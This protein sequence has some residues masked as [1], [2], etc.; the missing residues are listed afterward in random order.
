MTLNE[1]NKLFSMRHALW[2]LTILLKGETHITG[3]KKNM[4]KKYGGYPTYSNI[5]K[6]CVMMEK[7]GLIEKRKV[8]RKHIVSLTLTGKD[9]AENI[10]RA[11]TIL[12]NK[13]VGK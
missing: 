9:I 4:C 2:T 3:I 6:K 7:M 13:K 5:H 8:G 10:K 12:V 1:S 11:E